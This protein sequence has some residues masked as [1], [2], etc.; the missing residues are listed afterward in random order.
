MAFLEGKWC[1]L[2]RSLQGNRIWALD[3]HRR[4]QGNR[5]RQ[6]DKLLDKHSLLQDSHNR[7][8]EG[9]L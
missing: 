2:H 8:P 4:A 3:I 7:Q 6:P 1:K 5:N 9:T